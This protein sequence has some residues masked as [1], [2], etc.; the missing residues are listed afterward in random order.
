ME[1]NLQLHPNQLIRFLNKP[2]SQF[3]KR[4]IIRF[5]VENEFKMINFRYVAGDGRLKTLNFVVSSLVQ[6]DQILTHGERVDG[7]SIFYYID[8]SQSDLYVIPRF[9]TAFVNPFSEIPT[10]DI[11]CSYYTMD[12]TKLDSAPENIVE[13]AHREFTRST[14][15]IF[16]AMG[17]LE[18]YVISEKDTLYEPKTQQGYH[19]SSP[20]SKWEK[21]RCEAMQMIAQAGGNIKYGH[22]EVGNIIGDEY[23]MEQHEIEFLPAPI[24]EAADQIV[25]AKWILRMLGY[26]YGVSISFAPKVIVGHAGSGLHIH[27]KLIKDNKNQMINNGK[28]SETALKSIVGYLKMAP[29]LTA[30][31]NTVPISYLR[32]V[33]NQEAPT[34]VCWGDTNRSAL[35][36]VPLGWL[37]GSDMVNDA[38]PN[39]TEDASQIPEYQTVEFR[40]PDGSANIHFLLAGLAMAAKYGFELEDAQSIS[41]QLYIKENVFSEDF[42]KMDKELRH[43]PTSC[44]QSSNSLERNRHIYEINNVFPPDLID[45][46]IKKLRSYHDQN[47]SEE[48]FGK[49]D[50]IKKLVDQYLYAF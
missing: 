50:D 32:L 21:L 43:L 49:I 22:S 26:K 6:L 48:L 5:F 41:K 44:W 28:L 8:P 15:M 24:E 2:S 30:F 35:V 42:L 9:R 7:S 39:E 23:H 12:G 4:D 11:L 1:N 37:D 38:N 40:A 19:E 3:T 18:Y 34:T 14:G 10:I 46:I 25:L 47:L 16:T 29:S 33:P 13:K 20:F 36:R 27:T 31:G 45:G 17:E